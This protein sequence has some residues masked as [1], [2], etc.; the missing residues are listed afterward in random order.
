MIGTD[1]ALATPTGL[2]ITDTQ[3]HWTEAQ[4]AVLQ[5][6]GCPPTATAAQLDLFF[7][8]AKRSGLD[9]FARQIYM[10]SYGGQ[11]TIQTGIDGFRVI[12]RRAADLA[13]HKLAYGPTEWRAAKGQWDDVWTGEGYPHAARKTVYR[14]GEPFTAVCH[15]AEFV[16][17]TMRNNQR[18]PNSMWSSKPAHMIGK[19]AEAAALRMAFPH[20]LSALIA[21]EEADHLT[22]PPDVVVMSRGGLTEA[23]E[24]VASAT[25]YPEL[26]A[27][28]NQRGPGLGLAEMA[29]LQK[30][31]AA[32]RAELEA[33]PPA[34]APDEVAPPPLVEVAQAATPPLGVGAEQEVVEGEVTE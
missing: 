22:N 24:L 9:P 12:A 30:A 20:D 3:T 8:V 7:H 6:T 5:A 25:S 32:R 16:G 17:L 19:C 21:P 2:A 18:V 11:P 26:V 28:F 10:V 27:I 29:Q 23:L 1:V 31:C 15:F 14:D 13:G 34:P 33:E 4:L